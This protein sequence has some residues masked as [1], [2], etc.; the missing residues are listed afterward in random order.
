MPSTPDRSPR[1]PSTPLPGGQF[2]TQ[3]MTTS[4]TPTGGITGNITLSQEQFDRL[5]AMSGTSTY[6][7]LEEPRVGGVTP[8]GVWTGKGANGDGKAPKTSFCM[9]AF[10]GNPVKTFSIRTSIQTTV[11]EGLNGKK[12]TAFSLASEPNAGKGMVSIRHLDKLI[13][14]IGLDGIFCIQ[15][16]DGTEINMLKTPG[17]VTQDL[18]DTWEKD[19]TTDGVYK[20]D[21]QGGKHKV[22]PRD[23]ENL[24][25]S[26]ET[27]L[28]SCTEPLSLHIQ[29]ALTA[30]GKNPN[31]LQVLYQITSKCY[32]PSSSIVKAKIL[33]LEAMDL[34]KFPGE[35]VTLF[36]QEASVLLAEIKLNIQMKNQVPD[37][38][39]SALLG[40]TKGTDLYFSLQVK[41]MRRK[42][43]ADLA[44]L[45]VS[46]V[47]VEKMYDT[48]ETLYLELFEGEDYAPGIQAA[49]VLAAQVSPQHLA[50]EAQLFAMQAQVQQLTQDRSASST[51]G[52][53]GSSRGSGGG[54]SVQCFKCGGNHMKKDCP[55]TDSEA[56]R[57]KSGLSTEDWAKL[58]ALIKTKV[59]V[60]PERSAIPD[61]PALTVEL[62]GVTKAKYCR[63]C[64]RYTK[65][66][67]MHSTAEHRGTRKFDYVPPTGGGVAPPAGLVAGMA[68]VS[69]PGTPAP[70]DGRHV[71]FPP[72]P[73]LRSGPHTSYDFRDMGAREGDSTA[74][75]HL[76]ASQPDSFWSFL[77]NDYGPSV[78]G[79]G[80]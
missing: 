60:L 73:M 46:P 77:G 49:S 74:G 43:K 59:D 11:E 36:V 7:A 5:V 45:A 64:G 28:N 52:N 54:S 65:S 21:T 62:N 37:L 42:A 71:H 63:H 50:L 12:L 67:G 29:D 22:C 24:Q 19:L 8:V 56:S 80:R 31:G 26:G 2:W 20:G 33:L 48:L 44:C 18:V 70:S 41:D 27:L 17:F 32:R 78:K 69:P 51:T 34:R 72:E 1:T 23:I 14:D 13:P 79:R 57:L 75:G 66:A 53:G 38:P 47:Q 15:K 61:E 3:A 68:Q 58:N 40:L 4:G 25:W 10:S 6:A 76:A 35:S 39:Q 30:Q 9:R 16:D 55:L